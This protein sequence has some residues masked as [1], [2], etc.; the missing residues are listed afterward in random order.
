MVFYVFFMVV[1]MFFMFFLWFFL[2]FFF[3]D[4]KMIYDFFYVVLIVFYGF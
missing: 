4:G 2:W 1:F 3:Y